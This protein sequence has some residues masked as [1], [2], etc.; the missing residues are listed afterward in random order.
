MIINISY[1]ISKIINLNTIISRY[2][3][4][5]LYIGDYENPSKQSLILD[6]GS[7][8]TWFPW[9]DFCKECGTHLN[10][11]YEVLKSNTTEF[12]DCQKDGWSCTNGN[13]WS[14]TQSYGEGSTYAGFWIKDKV[15]LDEQR[16]QEDG[17]S[18]ILGC[19]ASE[20]KLF[21]SQEADGKLNY[22][23]V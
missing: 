15:Y 22:L 8:I 21:K 7:G 9:K 11:Y 16:H 23:I 10:S 20:T 12:L 17:I 13:K 3:Y 1:T 18:I 4:T 19:V 14:F 2:Y 5:N 6:T